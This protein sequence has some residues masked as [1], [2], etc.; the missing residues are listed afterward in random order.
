M[1]TK[2]TV[3]KE[4]GHHLPWRIY[5]RI[6]KREGQMLSVA[7]YNAI[8]TIYRSSASLSPLLFESHVDQSLCHGYLKIKRIE[9][10]RSPNYKHP[11]QVVSLI[12]G[13]R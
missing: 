3:T 12:K 10:Q 9:L 7:G 5:P 13:K 2:L 8:T 6:Y 1:T 4:L 11:H